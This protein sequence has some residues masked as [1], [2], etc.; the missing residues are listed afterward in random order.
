MGGRTEQPLLQRRH[1]DGQQAH[2][3]MLNIAN[4]QR[5]INQ[6][7]DELSLH[8]SHNGAVTNNFTNNKCWGG[9]KG[10]E[11]L[12]YYWWECKL[13]QTL[14]KTVWRFLRKPDVEPPYDPAITLSEKNKNEFKKGGAPQ[15]SQ[16]HCFQQP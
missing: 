6:N 4:Y 8:A 1:T 13:E 3:K 12:V 11:T 16:R 14:W 15:C 10:K 2:E 9:C 5:N 7:S